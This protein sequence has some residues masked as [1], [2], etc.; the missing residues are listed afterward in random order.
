MTA[1]APLKGSEIPVVGLL[2]AMVPTASIEVFYFSSRKAS[3][4]GITG[5]FDAFVAM[6]RARLRRN[7]AKTGDYGNDDDQEGLDV[8]FF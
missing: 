1:K 3:S 5:P 6:I 8:H 7:R 4:C 2:V